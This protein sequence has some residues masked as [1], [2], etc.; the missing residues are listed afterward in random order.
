MIRALATA[1]AASVLTV[2]LIAGGATAANAAAIA[3]TD[4]APTAHSSLAAIQKAGQIQTER[5]LVALE[6]AGNRVDAA[7][8]LSGDQ[9]SELNARLDEGS[10]EM[11]D[12]QDAIA[13]ATTASEAWTAYQ[14]MFTDDRIYAVVL[15]QVQL[16]AAAD[17]LSGTTIPRLQAGHDRLADALAGAHAD[18]STPELQSELDAMQQNIDDAT[19]TLAGLADDALAVTPADYNA[20][21]TVL[22]SLR[23]QLRNA[24]SD[25]KQAAQHGRSILAAI[26]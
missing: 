2:A 16:A 18:Q 7:V 25:L 4:G 14:A 12:A 1:T 19:Q 3:T 15:P 21:H 5:R 23:T 17:R 9:K 13:G 6:N 22:T 10:S 8:N 24:A 26:K 11:N 20:D